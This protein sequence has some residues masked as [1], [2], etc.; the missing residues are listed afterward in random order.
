MTLWNTI[1]GLSSGRLRAGMVK[2]KVRSKR[3]S[4]IS[5]IVL[6]LFVNVREC[7]IQYCTVR[8]SF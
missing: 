2:Y 8:D 7:S 4:L 3:S 1:L 6:V 5:L